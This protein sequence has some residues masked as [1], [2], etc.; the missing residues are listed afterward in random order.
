M[1]LTPSMCVVFSCR[2]PCQCILVPLSF[3][4]LVT[5]TMTC[6]SKCQPCREPNLLSKGFWR[7]LTHISPASLN[8]RAW[9]LSVEDFGLIQVHSISIK[10]VIIE[11][12]VVTTSDTVGHSGLIVRADIETVFR[13]H[14][15]TSFEPAASVTGVRTI[16]PS[17]HARVVAFEVR[18][19]TCLSARRRF[20]NWSRSKHSMYVILLWYDRW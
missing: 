2:I 19:R 17:N 5:S 11:L 4:L 10:V 6:Y 14:A 20:E 3:R 15:S 7:R 8:P 12:K 9:I 13:F 16:S 1:P 18:S